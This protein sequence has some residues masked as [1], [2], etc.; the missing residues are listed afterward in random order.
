MNPERRQAGLDPLKNA[1]LSDIQVAFFDIDGTLIKGDHSVSKRVQRALQ[2]LAESGIQL[3]LASGRPYFAT[4][5]L[6]ETLPLTGPHLFFAGAILLG[7][8][9][10]EVLATFP[11][12]PN[13]V[14]LLLGQTDVYTEVYTKDTF[15]ISASHP[16]GEI[17]AQYLGHPPVVSDLQNVI[18]EHQILK[19]G[20]IGE[21]DDPKLL[22]AIAKLSGDPRIAVATARGAAHPKLLFVN[23]TS[24]HAERRRAFKSLLDYCKCTADHILAFGDGESDIPFLESAK[25]GVA[26]GNSSERVKACAAVV[27][28]SVEEDGVAVAIE[29]LAA[30]RMS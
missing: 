18:R 6:F 24:I 15:F 3:G 7:R 11:L 20:F 19:L 4:K 14:Q 1:Q 8:S 21:E 23:I 16:Y 13:L 28:H 22:E 10:S 25:F 27:T 26:M 5:S 30:N 2:T 12:E 29:L 17:H 9:S